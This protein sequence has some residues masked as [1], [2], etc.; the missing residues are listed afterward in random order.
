MLPSPDLFLELYTELRSPIGAD[1]QL[2]TSTLQFLYE[3]TDSI[4]H[5]WD[6]IENNSLDQV[7]RRHAIYGACYWLR[8]VHAILPPELL[9]FLREKILVALITEPQPVVRRTLVR[10]ATSVIDQFA[11]D[12][13]ELV[14]ETTAG[15]LALDVA[16]PILTALI[17]KLPSDD[18]LAN[19]PFFLAAIL[20]GLCSEDFNEVCESGNF[21]ISLIGNLRTD[22]FFD[23]P[24]AKFL[25]IFI[26]ASRSGPDCDHFARLATSLIHAF[27]NGLSLLPFDAI[28]DSFLPLINSD[29]FDSEYRLQL[30]SFLC[31]SLLFHSEVTLLPDTVELLFETEVQLIFRV[32]EMG[33]ADPTMNWLW[34]ID[35]MLHELFDRAPH[36]LILHLAFG[37][38]VEMAGIS[39]ESAKSVIFVLCD[40][41][42]DYAVEEFF[43]HLP[44]IFDLIIQELQRPG[45][46]AQC[47]A[48]ELLKN[49]CEEFAS[50]F[51]AN[52]PDN[53]HV[54]INY[55]RTCDVNAGATLLQTMLEDVTNISGLF[56]LLMTTSVDMI[57]NPSCKVQ[58]NGF[59][60]IAKIV[61]IH[62]VPA[63]VFDGVMA[64]MLRL[65]AF[66]A[67]SS[68]VFYVFRELLVVNEPRFVKQFPGLAEA[69]CTG[70]Q[71]DDPYTVADVLGFLN[72]GLQHDTVKALFD[73]VE[74]H[75]LLLTIAAQGH[76]EEDSS[77][78]SY[79]L[80]AAA[81]LDLTDEMH[82]AIEEQLMVFLREGK[83]VI[84][85]FRVFSLLSDTL[86]H[87]CCS[88]M[89]EF[90]FA[91]LEADD[92]SLWIPII[93]AF[94]S[95]LQ[96]GDLHGNEERFVQIMIALVVQINPHALE[97]QS[98]QT[99]ESRIAQ[100]LA[101]AVIATDCL[102]VETFQFLLEL[103]EGDTVKAILAFDAL[104]VFFEKKG[105]QIPEDFQQHVLKCT[106]AAIEAARPRIAQAAAIFL[107]VAYS[108]SVFV[109]HGS[110]IFQTLAQRLGAESQ[111]SSLTDNL[112]F[113]VT[114]LG[115]NVLGDRFPVRTVLEV[116]LPLLPVVTE[117]RLSNKIY[118]FLAFLAS[119]SKVAEIGPE[120]R[121]GIVKLIIAVLSDTLRAGALLPRVR[122]SLK[123]VLVNYFG[124]IDD[125]EGFVAEALKGDE[126]LIGAF[127]ESFTELLAEN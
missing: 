75:E 36:D 97:F 55:M 5:L 108:G 44:T 23:E 42:L 1:M 105:A 106:L 107:P 47:L 114:Q 48:S 12:W 18:V 10:L 45:G 49:R 86:S 68:T 95:V 25:E 3:L 64:T 11:G 80:E 77:A 76:S 59:L 66:E 19:V 124:T 29:R 93:E 88:A 16:R 22:Q 99:L 73:P 17:Y 34:D 79:A 33:D 117:F 127:R 39:N 100:A 116:V 46:V 81:R 71:A 82:D 126:A 9:D 115:A 87:E 101:L 110:D 53:V 118:A 61:S 89:V 102:V 119:A 111:K 121:V 85:G 35:A 21:L 20:T 4:G 125:P 62:E 30:H 28:F 120:L 96:E 15:R 92:D 70:L 123:T 52:L 31:S 83:C 6:L 54:L 65:M 51:Q 37:K 74:L 104:A 103:A 27:D 41:T 84:G 13:P 112:V 26:D 50:E 90:G 60:I 67:P 14:A 72:R 69:V 113:A 8:S 32:L 98:D 91:K 7:I 24:K 122:V 58:Y 40:S 43:P 38:I 57:A 109:A 94:L 56:D 63:N 2:V 78:S